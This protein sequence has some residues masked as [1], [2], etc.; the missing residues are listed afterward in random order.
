MLTFLTNR[1]NTI[2]VQLNLL[3][4]KIIKKTKEIRLHTTKYDKMNMRHI[5]IDV[6]H[7]EI[8]HGNAICVYRT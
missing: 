8:M 5:Y 3:S 2:E 7:T 6:A 4:L 1:R